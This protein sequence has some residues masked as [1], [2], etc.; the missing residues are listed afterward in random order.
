M[1]NFGKRIFLVFSALWLC[2]LF[3]CKVSLD[4]E[5]LEL[6]QKVESLEEENS[7]KDEKIA[8]LEKENRESKEKY[9]S[10]L[11]NIH[12]ELEKI[13]F[14]NINQSAENI[15][16]LIQ[17]VQNASSQINLLSM[18]AMIEAAH[19][20]EAGKEFATIADEIRKL[21]E[22]ISSKEK[23]NEANLTGLKNYME[24]LEKSVNDIKQ[25]VSELIQAAESQTQS[26]SESV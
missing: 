9:L 16:E 19:S 18:N 22:E 15:S 8:S 21:S 17:T 26:E 24:E 2:F 7:E 6:Q 14:G 20:G 23:E 11:K 25:K 12:S 3:G 10:D 13:S 4:D 5:K 1:K